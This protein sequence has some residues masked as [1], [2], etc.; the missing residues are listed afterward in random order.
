MDIRHPKQGAPKSQERNHVTRI[1]IL[2][3]LYIWIT[4]PAFWSL[5]LH[6]PAPGSSLASPADALQMLYSAPYVMVVQLGHWAWPF[7][8][9]S[10]PQPLDVKRLFP[11]NLLYFIILVML[12]R[13]AYRLR[14]INPWPFR[15]LIWALLWIM[16]VSGMLLFYPND[17]LSPVWLIIPSMGLAWATASLIIQSGRAWTRLGQIRGHGDGGGKGSTASVPQ[18]C[19][20]ALL[21]LALVAW[22][23]GLPVETIVRASRTPDQ[24]V[25]RTVERDPANFAAALEYALQLARD[26]NQAAA[27]SLVLDVQRVAPWY[28]DLPVIKAKLL[29]LDGHPDAALHHLHSALQQQP[30]NPRAQ[31]LLLEIENQ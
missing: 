3:T 19:F 15:G 28:G 17:P 11:A 18:L 7:G 6:Q 26:G 8:R 1:W 9:D 10:S 30:Q 20:Y 27:T 16:P 2:L 31:A 12:I 4:A 29:W 25:A 14:R 5:W 13:Q 23:L 24:R 22:S 21:N